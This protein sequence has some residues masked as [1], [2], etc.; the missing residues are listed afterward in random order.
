MKLKFSPTIRQE[1]K[2]FTSV[3]KSGHW[4][5]TRPSVW[6]EDFN[7]IVCHD[8]TP[9]SFS[10][11]FPRAPILF[12][13][14]R[15]KDNRD[16]LRTTRCLR[17]SC[18][19]WFWFGVF[20]HVVCFRWIYTIFMIYELLFLLRTRLKWFLGKVQ[21]F[22][23][24]SRKKKIWSYR[25]F[26]NTS[27]SKSLWGMIR[28]QFERA[29][30]ATAGKRWA[31]I[32]TCWLVFGRFWPRQS[33]CWVGPKHVGNWWKSESKRLQSKYLWSGTSLQ[34]FRCHVDTFTRRLRLCLLQETQTSR[35]C[36]TL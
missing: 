17:N 36:V 6:K 4:V 9:S 14:E 28:Q 1:S 10:K 25:D 26:L 22:P 35:M 5:Y 12:P 16:L 33:S 30:N 20:N 13:A 27:T 31:I 7:L 15:I 11:R 24:P 18:S 2:L 34:G 3:Q 19:F 23:I 21:S 32:G 8:T 29:G